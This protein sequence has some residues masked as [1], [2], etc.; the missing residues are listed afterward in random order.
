MLCPHK[1]RDQ[2]NSEKSFAALECILI[3]K[4]GGLQKGF[5]L[6]TKQCGQ[7]DCITSKALPPAVFTGSHCGE[8]LIALQCVEQDY[9]LF[10]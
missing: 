3:T 6:L 8:L 2:T 7:Y 4:T 1:L 10:H 5:W 9:I